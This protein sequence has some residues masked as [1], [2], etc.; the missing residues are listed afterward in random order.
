ML[1]GE[2]VSNMEGK[3]E[4]GDRW[5]KEC[6]RNIGAPSAGML[7]ETLPC[8]AASVDCGSCFVL[9]PS[10]TRV[11]GIF[12]SLDIW[13][14]RAVGSSFEGGSPSTFFGLPTGFVVNVVS[15]NGFHLNFLA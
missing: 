4:L 7:S 5:G 14:F 9:D 8:I 6:V 10:K 3:I 13:M 15:S 1:D 12:G 2:G 11:A